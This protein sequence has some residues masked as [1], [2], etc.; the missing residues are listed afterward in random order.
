MGQSISEGMR[1]DPDRMEAFKALKSPK[2]SITYT[3]RVN[4]LC[5]KIC[6]RN[7]KTTTTVAEND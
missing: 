5:K 6:A 1:I 3:M 4:K 7:G 2:D